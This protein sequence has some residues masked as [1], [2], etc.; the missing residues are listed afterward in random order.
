MT[1]ER[2]LVI[3]VLLLLIIV[4]WRAADLNLLNDL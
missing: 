3:I 2:A 1:F 4:L